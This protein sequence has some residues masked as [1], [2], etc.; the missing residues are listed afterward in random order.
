MYNDNNNNHYNRYID[1]G[2]KGRHIEEGHIDN[3]DSEG[4]Y[5]KEKAYIKEEEDI[6]NISNRE[7]GAQRIPRRN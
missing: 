3:K 6:Y 1:K 7:Q 4:R 5:I 2:S